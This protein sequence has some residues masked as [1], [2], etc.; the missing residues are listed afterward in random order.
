[1]KKRYIFLMSLA[2]TAVLSTAVLPQNFMP[3]P[4]NV[5]AQEQLPTRKVSLGGSLDQNGIN[6]TLQ[7]LNARDVPLVDHI[8]VDGPMIN[9]YLRD[10]SNA[11]TDVYSSA[12]IE[13]RQPGYGVQVQIVT[14]Q[15][16]LN[17]SAATYQNAAITSGAR[18]VLIKIASAYPVT[19]EGALTGVYAIYEANGNQLNQT[20][21]DV[22]QKEITLPGQIKERVRL[23]DAQINEML[24]NIKSDITAYIEENGSISDQALRAIIDREVNAI[25]L[26]YNI[27]IPPEVNDIIFNV[28]K[29]YAALETER[30][31]EV[32]D[33][34]HQQSWNMEQAIDIFEFAMDNIHTPSTT[35]LPDNYDSGKWEEVSREGRTTI[36]QYEELY[37]RFDKYEIDTSVMIGEN[38]ESLQDDYLVSYIINNSSRLI[39]S[40]HNP[41]LLPINE[42][43][44]P[45]LINDSNAVN[46]A[47]AVLFPMLPDVE[48]PLFDIDPD[49]GAF[50]I[51][52][53]V[54]NPQSETDDYLGAYR[55]FPDGTI[56][57]L[58]NYRLSGYPVNIP[59]LP[60]EDGEAYFDEEK[61]Q[62]LA[63]F[64]E[65]WGQ[66]MGQDY[67]SYEPG[68][69]GNM[70][71][72][73]FPS[74]VIENFAAGEV[75]T[76]AHW[77]EDGISN[78]PGD[79]AVVAAYSDY[80]HF[81]A[82]NPNEPAGAHYYLFVL[83]DGQP[84][85]MH[86]QQNQGQPNNLVHFY[87]TENVALQQGFEQIVQGLGLPEL[88]IEEPEETT[89]EETTVGETTVEETTVGETT[90]EE[91]TVGETT[92][93]E[94]TSEATTVSETTVE[95]TTV[96][97]TT[98]GETTVE[99]TTVGETTVEETTSEATTVGE[100]TV[101]ETTVEET[102]SLFDENKELVLEDFMNQ[103]GAVME[104][105]YEQ[106]TPG[107]EGNMYGVVFPTD[108]L[109]SLA[110]NNQS[111]AAYW[112]EE[113]I[114]YESG[115]YAIV[116]AYHNYE[117]FSA[118]NPGEPAGANY[119]LFAIV[120]EQP[121]VLVSQQNETQPDGL[122]H[123]QPTENTALQTAFE[124]IV[125]TGNFD[126]ALL[127]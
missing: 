20:N 104:Q 10:G 14:P 7:L 51:L 109:S 72:L 53:T 79:F 99:E 116:A 34:S 85:V 33:D 71:G 59:T 31:K 30:L 27:Q 107:Q 64:M 73:A 41:P 46:F 6:Y 111:V 26:K 52:F 18:D 126:S 91:T 35:S 28:M 103:W 95:E 50:V 87:Q 90:V 57:H 49:T 67:Q 8:R 44:D 81:F 119:Y 56:D 25:A 84:I 48:A 83:V 32:I 60:I 19:G 88:G 89:V 21:I 12:I 22:A 74:D 61:S 65:D 97:E 5:S 86:S 110:V 127:Q 98:V 108:V 23:N 3:T 120:N 70:F 43:G 9:H 2:S 17:V 42:Q 55:I 1:M 117:D 96:E 66:V 4:L 118:Q 47:R 100:T 78:N 105:S 29:E 82:T 102:T 36:L 125:D 94:T 45:V 121:I 123:F 124:Q 122:I 114:S 77:S 11:Q 63:Q 106:F 75:P 93:E 80:E 113:G 62:Q 112:S 58:E 101:V 16:I 76:E 39:L 15:T 54:D 38:P 13:P 24:T 40:Q 115:D 69:E 68:Q 37:Y 92:V